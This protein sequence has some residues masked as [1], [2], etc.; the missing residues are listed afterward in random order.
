[1]LPVAAACDTIAA[2]CDAAAGASGGQWVDL[3]ASAA[4]AL[5]AA[6]SGSVPGW[7]ANAATHPCVVGGP[8]AWFACDALM[9]PAARTAGDTTAS[10]ATAN[11]VMTTGFMLFP[12]KSNEADE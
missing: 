7:A 1:V 10:M 6:S 12:V 4:V 9:L 2:A 3:A 11:M 8:V 5:A